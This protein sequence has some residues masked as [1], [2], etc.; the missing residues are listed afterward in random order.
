[1]D[2]PVPSAQD[3]LPAGACDCHAHVYGPPERYP[4]RPGSRYV[5]PAKYLADYQLMLRTT[6]IDHAVIVQPTVYAN[7]DVTA[8]ALAASNG[9]WRGIAKFT[10]GSMSA[11]LREMNRAG[12]RGV[13]VH[14]MGETTEL[15]KLDETARAI[16]P[17]GW[18]IQ[19][20]MESRLLPE[21]EARLRE[22]PVP[23]VLDH[24]ARLTPDDGET[25]PPMQALLRLLAT[26][27]CWLKLS[28]Y[29][30]VSRQQFPHPDLQPLAKTL[31]AARP[32]RMVWGSDWPHPSYEGPAI[33]DTKLP[34]L[35][36]GWAADRQVWEGMLVRNPAE[37]YGF[38]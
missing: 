32:D 13:R 25:S 26:G 24:F 36:H 28:G 15:A 30:H 4:L 22:L 11:D 1:M 19:L 38:A 33:D 10:D 29:N 16:A 9:A 21:L 17:F 23:V 34:G 31:I 7:N 3:S 14:G 27:K 2:T 12:F 6:G 37:L 20:H 8:D 5:P 18:H 35:L